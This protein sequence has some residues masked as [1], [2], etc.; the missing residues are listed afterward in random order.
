M[1]TAITL[2]TKDHYFGRN[3][4]LEYNYQEAVTITPRNFPFHFRNGGEI[5]KHYGIIGIAT[6][7]DGYPL[8]YDA[9]NEKGLSIAGLNF[10]GNAVYHAR[11]DEKDNIA[12]FELIPWILSQCA[13][14]KEAMH[15]LNRI[16]LTNI[17]FNSDYPISDLH[18][19][20]AD[21]S[22]AI[23]IEPRED[24]LRIFDNHVG[25]LT[26]NPPFD[27]HTQ[28]LKNYLNLTREEPVN[29]FAPQLDFTPYSRGMGA[30]G[31]PGDL[32]SS[33]R[34]I[35]AVFTKYNSVCAQ[36]EIESVNQFF[37]ILG[38]VMQQKGCV[39]VGNAFEK[40]VYAS[41][42]NI[43]K[44]IYYYKTYNNTQISGVSLYAENL[45]GTKLASYPLITDKPF[46]IINQ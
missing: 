11:D 6:I 42:C 25:V 4:D 26:N 24:G 8:Y 14:V 2:Q 20:L 17:S 1:C 31:L 28:N 43:D 9:T 19:I 5:S 46:T 37:H 33:S 23:T 21:R 3:L 44:G 22:H 13:T 7:A 16:N 15:E 18:W 12:P 32:S 34:F 45:D 41:C 38:S 35:R 27:Y 36:N 29:R 40:T 30:M 39:C 10:P